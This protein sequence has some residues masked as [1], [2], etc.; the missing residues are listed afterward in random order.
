MRVSGPAY[1]QRPALCHHYR[2]SG[3]PNKNMTSG[4]AAEVAKFPKKCP[5]TAP[6][7]A[8]CELIVS[9]RWRC[10]LLLLLREKPLELSTPNLVHI[11]SPAEP[12]HPLTLRSKGQ[13]SRSHE[14]CHGRTAA[15]GYC[16]GVGLHVVRLLRF[17]VTSALLGT[18]VHWSFTGSGRWTTRRCTRT[19]LL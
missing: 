8:V 6:I 10:S 3:L 16:S 2:K 13:R 17:L 5:A 9:L 14:N 1:P 11:Y 12:P 4:F 19:T 18:S 15:R 7:S